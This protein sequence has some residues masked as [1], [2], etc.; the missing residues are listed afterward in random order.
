MDLNYIVSVFQ[1]V[2]LAVFDFYRSL[3]F[4]VGSQSV[5]AFDMLLFFMVVF[6]ISTF[7]TGGSDDD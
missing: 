5:T 4:V 6:V 7:F 1:S 3:T 2:A